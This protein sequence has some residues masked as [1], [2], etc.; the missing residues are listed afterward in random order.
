MDIITN[1]KDKKRNFEKIE[2]GT[3]FTWREGYYMKIDNCFVGGEVR[4]AVDLVTGNL[5]YFDCTYLILAVSMAVHV[6]E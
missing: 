4:N 1:K 5:V 6:C 3:A 2:I